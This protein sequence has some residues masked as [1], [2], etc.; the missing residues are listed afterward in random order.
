MA[1][2]WHKISALIKDDTIPCRFSVKM[3]M[4]CCLCPFYKDQCNG[5]TLQVTSRFSERSLE[6]SMA[7]IHVHT[8]STPLMKRIRSK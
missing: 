3:G 7:Y 8:R 2:Y 4:P 5:A 6:V 1:N